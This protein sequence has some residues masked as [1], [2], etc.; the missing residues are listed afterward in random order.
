MQ[1]DRSKTKISTFYLCVK[2]QTI[3]KNTMHIEIDGYHKTYSS[4]GC[5]IKML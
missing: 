4:E 3:L 2:T 1:I 5:M